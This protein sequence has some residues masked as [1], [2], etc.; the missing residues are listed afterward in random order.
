MRFN[1]LRLT[2]LAALLACAPAHAD[3]LVDTPWLTGTYWDDG[4]AEIAFYQVERT[5]NQYGQAKGQTF[6]VGTY[7]VK[8]DFDPEAEAKASS[9]STWTSGA[10]ATGCWPP[11]L[12]LK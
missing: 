11:G 4:Q 3:G 1:P 7:L 2:C 12:T 9:A 8:H 5:H 6:P 10:V